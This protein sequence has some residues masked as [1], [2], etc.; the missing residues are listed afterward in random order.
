MDSDRVEAIAI[1]VRR[2]IEACNPIELPWENF[3]RG[4]CG[5]A[6]LILGQVL[7]R[8]GI[9]GF[10]YVCGNKWKADGSCSSHAWLK[11]GK[12]IVDITADQF[13]DVNES[14]IVTSKSE[15]HEQ[16]EQDHPTP[17]TLQAHG[18][19]VPQLWRVLTLLEPRLNF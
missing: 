17:G 4:A 12:W 2:A 6:S 10:K 7:D 18:A 11:N 3:P 14:V 8:A 9:K 13:P 1:A 5:D 16:W 15:W 19:N